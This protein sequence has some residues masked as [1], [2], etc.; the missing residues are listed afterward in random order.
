VKRILLVLACLM[1]AVIALGF[2]QGWF[3]LS[4]GRELGSNKVDVQL[5]V[6]PDKVQSD[7]DQASPF[8]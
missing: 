7:A 5:T 6:D 2:Y 4:S 3:V 8:Q 1:I